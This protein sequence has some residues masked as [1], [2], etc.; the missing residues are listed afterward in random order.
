MAIMTKSEFLQAHITDRLSELREY[1]KSCVFIVKQKTKNNFQISVGFYKEKITLRM[2]DLVN[3][4]ECCANFD[5]TQ[6]TNIDIIKYIDGKAQ[7]YLIES[8]INND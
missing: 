3:K 1:A 5:I 4:F 2:T 7:L 8:E 6:N